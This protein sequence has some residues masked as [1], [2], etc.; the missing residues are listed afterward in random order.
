ML[1]SYHPGAGTMAQIPQRSEQIGCAQ[2]FGYFSFPV[3]ENPVM[4]GEWAQPEGYC[5]KSRII[6]QFT[7][8]PMP[9]IWL[10]SSERTAASLFAAFIKERIFK[11]LGRGLASWAVNWDWKMRFGSNCEVTPQDLFRDR[12]SVATGK[13]AGFYFASGAGLARSL[14]IADLLCVDHARQSYN[15]LSP[16]EAFWE[17]P[18]K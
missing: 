8:R 17:N 4:S 16:F 7:A 9:P 14:K 15:G 6:R 2:R 3:D 18:L 5:G 12:S 13:R 10:P 11:M 1:H